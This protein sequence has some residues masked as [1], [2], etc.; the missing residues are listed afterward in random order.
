[1]P[2][3][4]CSEGDRPGWKWGD[5]GKCYTYTPDSEYSEKRAKRKAINQAIAQGYKSKDIREE[6]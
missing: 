1:M 2:L 4:R 6:G 3:K 5:A